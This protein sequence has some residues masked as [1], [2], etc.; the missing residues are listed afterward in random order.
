M[1]KIIFPLQSKNMLSEI[2]NLH[3]V[4]FFF[5]LHL[6]N[7]E[8]NKLFDDPHFISSYT[9]EVFNQQF[10]KATSQL[11]AAFQDV[12][13]IKK[14]KDNAIDEL[15]AN[16]FNELLTQFGGLNIDIP[17]GY[18]FK[19][20]DDSKSDKKY[21]ISGKV[22]S[23]NDKAAVK[24][25]IAAFNQNLR[26][27]TELGRTQTND[28]GDFTITYE[29][30]FSRPEYKTADIFFRLYDGKKELKGFTV[31]QLTKAGNISLPNGTIFNA[32]ETTKVEISFSLQSADEDLSEFEMIT[33][34]I[35]PL[36][37][38]V[39]IESLNENDMHR[40]FSFL[41][42]ETELD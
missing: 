8:V 15:T 39:K 31:T 38:D 5:K 41:S 4:L 7:A 28:S 18:P 27:E 35:T 26:S 6:N 37:E 42:N 36:L 9:E 23:A 13:N 29:P 17:E 40:D 34:L 24:I 11:V 32:G 2:K 20:K 30:V 12:L 33:R 10:G 21:G 3:Y 14:R 22:K 1:N 25:T 16:K 19:V